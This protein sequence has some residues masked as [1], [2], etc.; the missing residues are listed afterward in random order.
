MRNAV[1]KQVITLRIAAAVLFG[2]FAVLPVATAA[3]VEERAAMALVESFLSDVTT[4]SSRFEQSLIDARGQVLERSTGT[5]E[6]ERPGRFRWVFIEPYEQWLL[7][8]GLNIWSYDVDLEQVTVKPQA[9]TLGNTPALLLSGADDALEQFVFD[10]GV[11]ESGLTWVRLVPVDT[12]SGFMGVELGFVDGRI[13]RMVFLDNLDQTTFVALAEVAIN[14]AIEPGTFDFVVP[15][16]VDV[17]GTP[18]SPVP[19]NPTADDQ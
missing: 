9:E 10:G 18:A 11:E 15:E 2:A 6:I 13:D 16:D 8:D 19:V 3:P 14:D 1:I 5:L 17:V 12:E 4:M 7:A